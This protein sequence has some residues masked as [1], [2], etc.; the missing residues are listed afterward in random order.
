M[1]WLLHNRFI[2]QRQAWRYRAKKYSQDK[3]F[4][5]VFLVAT[6]PDKNTLKNVID[7]AGAYNDVVLT[8]VKDGHRQVTNRY[9]VKLLCQIKLYQR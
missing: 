6:P 2:E 8:S 5:L 7:E 1:Y 9:W 4:R 3:I